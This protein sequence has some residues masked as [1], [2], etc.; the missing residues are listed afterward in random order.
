[1][2][3]GRFITLE[4]GEGAGKS[5]QAAL[6]AGWLGGRGIAVVASREPGGPAGSEAI[7]RFVK[8]TAEIAWAPKTEALLHYA[9]RQE[10]L[11]RLIRPSLAAGRWVVSD[12]FAD[13]TRA[14]QGAGQGIDAAW[15]DRL[16]AL[17]VGGDR[18]DL[19]LI[20][21]LDRDRAAHR[22]AGRDAAAPAAPAD[23]YEREDAAFHQ[24]VRDA[25]R[26]IAA[27]DPGRCR[28]IDGG[29]PVEAVAA[30]IRA[31]VAARFPAEIGAG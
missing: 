17:V 13:S 24:R 2:R 16:E 1:M 29:R 21:D 15:L 30:A 9:A 11:D 4:G 26:A 22:L 25:F 5:T 3:R 7:R 23:R 10:H 31:A 19:T 14:Y 12:R 18:P 28:I 6:L 8:G 20:L 27:A